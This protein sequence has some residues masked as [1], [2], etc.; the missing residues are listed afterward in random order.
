MKL[1]FL[2]LGIEK[3][4]SHFEVSDSV[5]KVGDTCKKVNFQNEPV[6]DNVVTKFGYFD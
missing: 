4:L 6:S 5:N 1:N 3:V 2:Y